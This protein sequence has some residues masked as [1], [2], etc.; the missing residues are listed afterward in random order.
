MAPQTQPLGGTQTMSVPK[1]RYCPLE[2]CRYNRHPV[3]A[4]AAQIKEHLGYHGFKNMLKTVKSLNLIEDY[5]RPTREE[6]LEILTNRSLLRSL[7]NA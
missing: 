6:L 7:S 2:D 1:D 4:D 5:A 3:K